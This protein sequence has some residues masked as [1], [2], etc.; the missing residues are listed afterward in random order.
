MFR[1]VLY[2]GV[3]VWMMGISL[4]IMLRIFVGWCVFLS[5]VFEGIDM[6]LLFGFVDKF[7]LK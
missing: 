5:S 3:M 7:M 2:F 1:Y 4:L 6:I